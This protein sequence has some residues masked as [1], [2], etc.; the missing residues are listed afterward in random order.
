MGPIVWFLTNVGAV[1]A[2]CESVC[3][4]FF[5]KRGLFRGGC[6]K[7]RTQSLKVQ[8][9]CPLHPS[10]SAVH[11]HTV[12]K[13]QRHRDSTASRQDYFVSVQPWVAG[14]L[15]TGYEKHSTTS[16]L[17][18]R[19]HRRRTVFR[20]TWPLENIRPVASLFLVKPRATPWARTRESTVNLQLVVGKG[21]V[22]YSMCAVVAVVNIAVSMTKCDFDQAARWLVQ[23]LQQKQQHPPQFLQ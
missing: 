12:S 3:Q 16:G 22:E 21:W 17:V 7:I 5:V 18:L 15:H 20:E 14:R 10:R 8:D 13:G 4:I 1:C 6:I 23:Q 19:L 9:L 11:A 2:A